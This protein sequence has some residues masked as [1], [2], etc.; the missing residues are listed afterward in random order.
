RMGPE[1]LEPSPPWLRARHAAANTW[2][3]KS[4][5]RE[6]NPRL[7]LIRGRLWP[8]SYGPALGPEG[9]EPP[10]Y[11]LKGGYAA[12]TPRPRMGRTYAFQPDFHGLD[13][14]FNKKGQASFDT[15]LEKSS[16]LRSRC[17]QRK[18]CSGNTKGGCSAWSRTIFASQFIADQ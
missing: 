2:I 10:P 4:A 1:G 11:R 6:L 7:A 3:P 15:W 12:I 14:F 18:G 8:L 5:R 16:P 13:S 17:Q 9:L